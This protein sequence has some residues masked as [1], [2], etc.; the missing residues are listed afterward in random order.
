VLFYSAKAYE[1]PF[2]KESGS[3]NLDVRFTPEELGPDTVI[4]SKGFDAV[5]IFTSD[6]ASSK[7]IGALTQQGVKFIAARSAGYDNIDLVT[8]GE[9]GIKVA[10]V[11]GYS[12]GA[13]AEHAVALML[14]LNRKLVK[15]NQQVHQ[16]NFTL[17]SLVGTELNQK[18]VGII[19]TG[20]IGATV[21]KILDG[22]GCTMLAYDAA[23]NLLLEEKYNLIYTGLLTLCSMCDII[24]IHLPLNAQTKYLIDKKL[25][26]SM[27]PGVM[28]INTARGAVV[29]TEDI[30]AGL[31]SGQ[32]GSYGLDVFENEKGIFFNDLSNKPI[33]DERLKRLLKFDNVLLTPHQG[34][35]TREALHAIAAST[36]NSLTCWAAGQQ[37]ANEIAL[38][39]VANGS[40]SAA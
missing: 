27:K 28:L 2:L 17:E 32:I 25:I 36:F 40:G 33:Y 39:A 35:A 15:A 21:V 34:F 5:S 7:V 29:Q 20:R 8:A 11:P 38:C 30:I 31:D 14:G 24:S 4:L 16:N 19:G 13:I 18:K 12:P 26:A 9:Y 6:D 3:S 10:H 37:P 23:P 22:F 1:L